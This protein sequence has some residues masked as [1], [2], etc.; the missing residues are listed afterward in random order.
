MLKVVQH[1]SKHCSFHLQCECVL[2]R[3]FLEALYTAG[4]RRR[5]GCKKQIGGAEEITNKSFEN[6]QH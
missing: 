4:S 2:V 5:V 6:V 1:F 3:C